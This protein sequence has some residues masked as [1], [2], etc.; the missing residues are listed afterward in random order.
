LDGEF[1]YF[2]KTVID[3][4]SASVTKYV[5]AHY[6][7]K[8]FDYLKTQIAAY[9][10]DVQHKNK[11]PVMIP[12]TG[13]YNE[14][15]YQEYLDAKMKAKLEKEL[16]EI[17][18]GKLEKT[19][20]MDKMWSPKDSVLRPSKLTGSSSSSLSGTK[21]GKE[22]ENAA[23]LSTPLEQQQ[24]DIGD[25]RL[26]KLFDELEEQYMEDMNTDKVGNTHSDVFTAFL[27]RDL[28]QCSCM[29]V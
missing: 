18:G 20:S 25:I 7:S 17:L 23:L 24:E 6:E 2:T 3:P 15:L 5:S 4:V 12:T 14:K 11:H 1:E 9:L 19:S 26:Y 29:G 10:K 13:V 21:N 8:K 22:L 27:I 16:E 28:N